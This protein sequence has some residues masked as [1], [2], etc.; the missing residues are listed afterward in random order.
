MLIIIL[1]LK[2]FAVMWLLN[3]GVVAV[4]VAVA[5]W[6]LLLYAVAV[7][8]GVIAAVNQCNAC[9]SLCSKF[10]HDVYVSM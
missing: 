8:V 3:A 4:T 1:S 5:L 7:T 2:S 6:L 10:F 9:V